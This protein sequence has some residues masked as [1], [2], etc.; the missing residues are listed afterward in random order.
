MSDELGINHKLYYG[1]VGTATG[2]TSKEV[3]LARDVDL[4]LNGTEVDT[5]SRRN[6]GWKSFRQGLKEWGFSFDMI[7]DTA[8]PAWVFLRERFWDG[9]AFGASCLDKEDGVGLH[10][11]VVVTGFDESEP[12]DDI[13]TT[14]VT[15]K[16]AGIPTW[17]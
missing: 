7:K 6:R 8:D 2:D 9:A 3:D 10:G 15:I 13:A 11:K 4:T 14:K 12:L 17:G 16:G 5:T 1:G